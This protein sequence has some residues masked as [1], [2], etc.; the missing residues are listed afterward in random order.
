MR[1][2][3]ETQ[4]HVIMWIGIILAVFILLLWVIKNVAPRH[5]D[6]ETVNADLSDIKGHINSA[7][8]SSYYRVEFNPRTFMGYLI[9]NDSKICID[10]HFDKCRLLMCSA[11]IEK[12]IMLDNITYLII[13][14]NDNFSIDYE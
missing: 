8:I 3:A 13:E 2:K 9:I 1:K 10:N 4:T 12:V 7:C 14:K 5:L 6:L 11:G